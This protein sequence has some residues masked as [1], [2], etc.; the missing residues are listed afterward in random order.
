MLNLEPVLSLQHKFLI[1]FT[2]FIFRNTDP[3]VALYLK[4]LRVDKFSNSEFGLFLK[5][6]H[7]ELSTCNSIPDSTAPPP[8]KHSSLDNSVVKERKFLSYVVDYN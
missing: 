5:I 3:F 8:I 1:S 6:L 2:L 7:L 4:L